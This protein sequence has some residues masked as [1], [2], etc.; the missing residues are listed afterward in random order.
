MKKIVCIILFLLLSVSVSAENYLINGGQKSTIRYQLL[1]K[2]EPAPGIKMLKMSLVIPKSFSSPTYNQSVDDIKIDIDPEP[3]K[4]KK[5]EDKRGNTVVELQW[6]NPDT[7]IQ[8]KMDLAVSNNTILKTIQSQVTFPVTISEREL[9][10]YLVSTDLVQSESPQIKE[11]AEYITRN[12]ETEFDAVQ[13]ILTWIIDNMRYVTPPEKYDA[14]YSFNS[15]KGNCQNYSHLAAAMMRAVNIPVRIVNGITLKRPFTVNMGSGDYTFKMGQGR[16]SWIEVYFPDLGWVPFDPQQ[17][18]LFVSNRFI[19]IEV[20]IDNQETVNDGLVRWVRSRG[21]RAKPS[22]QEVIE[23]DFITDNIELACTKQDYGPR[24]ML[25]CPEVRASFQ[26]V[27]VPKP[28]PP[29]KIPEKDLKELQ[30][31]KNFIFGNLDFPRNVNFAFNTTDLEKQSGDQ[32]IMKKN[33]MVETAEYVTTKLTQYAQ[34]FVLQKPVR[35]KKCALALHKFGGSGQLWLELRGDDNG[36]PGNVIATSDFKNLQDIPSKAGYDWIEFDFT[37]ENLK[38][39][40]GEYW[41]SLGFTGSPII[42]WFY[43]YGKP[44]GPVEGTRYKSVYSDTWSGALAYE[45]NYKIEGL[46][47]K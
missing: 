22:F 24:K 2:I 19:R 36:K 33:F 18:E 4:R 17:T 28:P 34:V 23:A 15:G 5:S 12:A 7:D 37:R 16:H 25:L 40:P 20:G 45:F 1:Q 42:N 10:E 29:K 21:G 46:T 14:L 41:I 44:V 47:V 11:K 27:S 35:M 30:F 31:T 38:L 43:T 13:Q 32:Y 6:K 3:D 39:Q 9:K 26:E 8:I